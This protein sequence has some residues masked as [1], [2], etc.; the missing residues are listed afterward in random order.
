M[1][2]ASPT[3]EDVTAALESVE[4]PEL[5]ISV[6]DLGLIYDVMVDDGSVAI[7]MTLTSLGCP[8]EDMLRQ[9]VEERVLAIEGVRE[10]S[11]TLVWDPP[12]TVDHM[13]DRGRE[14][15]HSFGVSV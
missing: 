8:A 2:D 3:V 5:P 6:V 1:A 15:L 14:Q 12:W 9:D 7:E 4:D 10:A 13:T 11:T